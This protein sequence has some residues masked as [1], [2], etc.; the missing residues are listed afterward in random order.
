MRADW[1]ALILTF[2]PAPS[3]SATA[4]SAVDRI[5]ELKELASA[6]V[7]DCGVAAIEEPSDTAWRVC[8]REAADRDEAARRLASLADRGLAIE[9]IEIADEDWARRSQAALTA[10]RVGAVVVSP[11]WDPAA[12]GAKGDAVVTVIEPVMGFGSGHHAT[13]RL[14]LAA[15][16]RIGPRGRDVVDIGTG[17]GV[18]AIA[19][20]QLGAS[21]VVGVEID[22]DALESA[23]TNAALNG[24][25][26]AVEFRLLDFRNV[27]VPAADIVLANLTGGMLLA[28]LDDVLNVCR[29]GGAVILSGITAEE[30]PAV[31]EAVARRARVEWQEE[32]AGWLGL[33][34][35]PDRAP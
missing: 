14:C 28:S 35:R 20:A 17:S 16:Q 21:H 15:L 33:I 29:P 2:T 13:T 30:G 6:G 10:I 34:A 11:P 26:P 18:L 23:R 24:N 22:P 12:Q 4:G 3:A 27:I 8:F 25:P 19:A 31:V 7:D 5:E 9:A 1:P 32:E